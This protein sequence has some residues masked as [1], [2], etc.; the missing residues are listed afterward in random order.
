MATITKGKTKTKIPSKSHDMKCFMCQ[1]F[2]HIASQ[3]PNKRV[4]FMENGDI[5][6]ARSSDEKM[7]SL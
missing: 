7:P 6:S 5:Y 3:C 4:I 2:G 1:G